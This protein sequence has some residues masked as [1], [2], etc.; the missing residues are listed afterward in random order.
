MAQDVIDPR[1][2]GQPID[3]QIAIVP[4]PLKAVWGCTGLQF[5]QTRRFSTFL[6]YIGR[7][8]R[9]LDLTRSTKGWIC[10]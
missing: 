4:P 6:Q 10:E 2:I 7:F 8:S 9:F 3:C 1:N 5:V